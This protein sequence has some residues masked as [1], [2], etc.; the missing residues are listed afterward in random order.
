[1]KKLLAYS[2]VLAVTFLLL[3]GCVSTSETQSGGQG[4]TST[5]TEPGAPSTPL[6]AAVAEPT[7][8]QGMP[9]AVTEPTTASDLSAVVPAG[10]TT[11][12][13]P[14]PVRAEGAPNA[15]LIF[16]DAPG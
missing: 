8:T 11:T 7:A 3:A 5:P 2:L 9:T 16:F 10:Q 14:V 1:M 15:T 4:T 13:E 12:P 6:P